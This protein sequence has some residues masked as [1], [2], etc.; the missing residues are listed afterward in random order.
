VQSV[1]LPFALVPV[2]YVAT[3][4]TIMGPT[5]VVRARLRAVVLVICTSL[6]SINLYLIVTTLLDVTHGSSS[7]LSS[8]G[9]CLVYGSFLS[10]LAVGPAAIHRWFASSPRPWVRRAAA[11]FG[12]ETPSGALTRAPNAISG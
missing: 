5:F 9:F 3:N 7:I 2:L 10:Y 4:T 1:Q 6:I 12:R 8:G 11:W